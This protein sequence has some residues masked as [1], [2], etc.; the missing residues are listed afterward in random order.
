MSQMTLFLA[1]FIKYSV[2][3]IASFIL[4]LLF[5]SKFLGQGNN[6]S[7]RTLDLNAKGRSK[8]NTK[9][10]RNNLKNGINREES[11]KPHFIFT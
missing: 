10:A 3:F 8:N 11:G 1:L 9:D 5:L 6:L 7:Q 4:T 2:L